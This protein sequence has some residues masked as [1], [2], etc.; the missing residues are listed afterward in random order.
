[1]SYSHYPWGW[2][3]AGDTPFRRWKRETYRGGVSDPF[4]VSWPK[5]INAKREKRH[6]YTHAIDLVPTVLEVLNIE[7][8]GFIKGVSQS[9]IEGVSFAYTFDNPTEKER[10]TTQY[11]E[12]FGHRSIYHDGWKAVCP[13]PGPSFKEAGKGFDVPLMA[14]DL[15]KLEASGWE[16]YHLTEDFSE[17][18]NVASKYPDKLRDLISRWWV[19][20]GKYDVLPID[21]R[22]MQRVPELILTKPR[23][24]K[25][26]NRFVYYPGGTVVP[27]EVAAEVANRS[28]SVTAQ[29]VIPKGGAE[30]V[31][32]SHGGRFG[33][34]SFYV[35]NNRLHY[36]HN[37]VGIERYK[38]GST[39]ELPVGE[40]K[41]TFEFETT[42]APDFP[43]GRGAGGKGRLY[44]NDEKVG[45]GDIPVTCPISY[46]LEGLLVGR[47]EGEPVTEDYRPPFE[48]TGT[49]KRVVVDASGEPFHHAELEGRIAMLRQ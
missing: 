10:H 28:H 16:L 43:H 36:V 49:L 8:P 41:L 17:S 35:K 34:Y 9:P 1:M 47:D 37:Y 45:E 40:C 22:L 33:G 18:H 12:M 30:G 13:W 25:A 23:V 3:G 38:V 29:V 31:I 39:R 26:R 20:A 27:F 7:S 46:G 24:E 15:E 2:T 32:L 6:Q 4:V 19:E 14:Q 48:F 11:Y 42:K 21:G 44:I 5:G